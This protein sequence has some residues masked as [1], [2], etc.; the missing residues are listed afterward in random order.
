MEHAVFVKVDLGSVS[1]LE[2]AIAFFGKKLAHMSARLRD[3]SF[4]LTARTA[5]IVLQLS[6]RLLE[7]IPNNYKC[8]LVGRVGFMTLRL[9]F[10][11]AL[12]KRSVQTW[13]LLDHQLR[14][15]YRQVNPDV[16][17]IAFP[18]VLVWK[19]DHHAAMHNAFV[20]SLQLRYLLADTGLHGLGKLHIAKG[21]LQGNY[22]RVVDLDN[23]LV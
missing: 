7:S 1:I 15:G 9:L 4:R 17:E 13:L 19:L 18:T 11:I 2:K 14:T 3:M 16:V 20:E 21:N 6:P 22:H 23:W 10:G 8:I 5:R 12:A